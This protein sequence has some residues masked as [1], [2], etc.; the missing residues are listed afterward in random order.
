MSTGKEPR[1]RKL[2]RRFV[3]RRRRAGRA[4]TVATH[5]LKEWEVESVF[6]GRMSEPALGRKSSDL[7]DCL[8]KAQLRSPNCHGRRD[9]LRQD[10][11]PT[12]ATI[13]TPTGGRKKRELPQVTL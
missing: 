10:C 6:G 13:G 11:H 4:F 2:G 8:R 7:M 9:R 3:N 12:E 1:I 5:K